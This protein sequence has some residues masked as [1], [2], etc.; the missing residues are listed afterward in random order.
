[1]LDKKNKREMETFG[2]QMSSVRKKGTFAGNVSKE[3]YLRMGE[4]TS[5]EVM[6]YIYRLLQPS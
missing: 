2:K 4:R 3:R 6:Q 5:P 1:M